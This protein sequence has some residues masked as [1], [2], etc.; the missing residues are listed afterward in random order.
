MSGSR[1]IVSILMASKDEPIERLDLAMGE[2]LAQS[3]TDF[4]IVLID[5][6]STNERCRQAYCD[7]A[8]RDRRVRL[9]VEAN[10]GLAAALNFG[11]SQCRG[12]LV[13]R[14]DSDD[15]SCRQRLA[16]QVERFAAQPDLVLLGCQAWVCRA[17]G[18]PLWETH[19]PLDDSDIRAFFPYANP[20]VHGSTMFRREIAQRVGGYRVEF[21][22]AEDYDFF[23]RMSAHGRLS[24]LSEPLYWHRK[25]GV[26]VSAVHA[27]RQAMLAAMIQQLGHARENGAIEDLEAARQKILMMRSASDWRAIGLCRRADQCLLAGSNRLA[28]LGY[29]KA[30]GESGMSMKAVAA[31][32]RAVLFMSL[33]SHTLKRRLFRA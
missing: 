9:F 11:L 4:E 14:H 26:S 19:L 10:R 13:A 16:L 1:P 25:T 12:E 5:D 15:W 31:L 27:E 18:T 8:L 33:P 22:G 21:N 6:G 7:W 28:V 3:F 23:W 17:D 29:L 24:N 30:I 20:F 2:L 32:I